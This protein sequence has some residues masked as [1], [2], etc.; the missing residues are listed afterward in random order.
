MGL[1]VFVKTD[2]DLSYPDEDYLENTNLYWLSRTFCNIIIIHHPQLPS[3]LFQLGELLDI[4]LAPMF[5]MIEPS[6]DEED[7]F[8]DKA[9]SE[10]EKEKVSREFQQRREECQKDIQ[11][12]HTLTQA[13][14]QALEKQPEA[15]R[16]IKYQEYSKGYLEGLQV[17][18]ADQ[19][20]DSNR[21]YIYNTLRDDLRNFIRSLDYAAEKGALRVYFTI[22]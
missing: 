9:E 18:F 12:M 16:R 4:D 20:I 3:E 7:F 17:Y 5:D 15:S 1:D 10:E 8:V 22:G 19:S 11:Q 21:S 2:I 6:P 14:L 13:F